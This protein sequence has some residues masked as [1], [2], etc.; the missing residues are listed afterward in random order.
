MKSGYGSMIFFCA[1]WLVVV[2]A[3]TS[4]GVKAG[5]LSGIQDQEMDIGKGELNSAGES[6]TQMVITGDLSLSDAVK[7]ALT[8]NRMLQAIVEDREVAEGRITEA[9]GYVFPYV[10]IKGSY[11]RLDEIS[12]IETEDGAMDLNTLNNYSATLQ[13]VQPV[14]HGGAL[15]AGIRAARLYRSLADANVQGVVQEVLFETVRLYY[16]VVLTMKQS[17]VQSE[18]VTLAEEHLSD[19][20]AKFKYG[21]ASKFNILRAEVELSNSKAQLVVF[22]NAFHQ[23]RL[24][25]FQS[26]GVS[27]TSDVNLVEDM[28]FRSMAVNEKSAMEDAFGLRPDLSGAQLM[29][30]LQKEAVVNAK[31]DY[32]PDLDA[33]YNYTLGKPDPHSSTLNKWGT[34]WVAGLSVH[35]DLF[36]LGR[37]GRIAQEKARLNKQKIQLLDTQEQVRFDVRSSLSSL[38]DVEA[39]VLAQKMTMDQANEGLRLAEVGYREGTLEQVAVLEARAALNQAKL[40]YWSSLYSHTVARLSVQRATGQLS[41]QK[42][43]T[44]LPADTAE[45]KQKMDEQNH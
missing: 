4:G 3:V 30:G 44:D 12:R 35:M 15:S 20:K 39:Y 40:L 42:I 17:Q 18:F 29:V 11:T 9:Y 7:I 5:E 14:Y 34:S 16:Q 13:V 27:Q 24:A 38:E 45:H 31:S 32:W 2:I 36:T 1:T 21:M 19:V 41:A 25:F 26:M 33:F 10:D 22:Q 43:E 6:E 23:A 8:H 28:T 37:E